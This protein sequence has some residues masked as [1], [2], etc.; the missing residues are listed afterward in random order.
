MDKSFID[1]TLSS[2]CVSRCLKAGDEAKAEECAHKIFNKEEGYYYLMAHYAEHN[3]TDRAFKLLAELTPQ[4]ARLHCSLFLTKLEK[5]NDREA[6]LRLQAYLLNS[7]SQEETDAERYNGPWWGLIQI[8]LFRSNLSEDKE[9]EAVQLTQ[10]VLE[11]VSKLAN[12]ARYC[13]KKGDVVGAERGLPGFDHPKARYEAM[14]RVLCRKFTRYRINSTGTL[15][16]AFRRHGPREAIGN[17][18]QR[19]KE[20]LRPVC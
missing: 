13:M 16:V 11:K 15:V 4:V 12:Y 8:A 10:S 19:I 6:L 14:V 18:N 3:N 2:F 17:I 7:N 20:S 5:A 1:G 9:E